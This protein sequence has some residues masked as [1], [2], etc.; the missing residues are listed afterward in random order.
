M[1]YSPTGF[2]SEIVRGQ[3]DELLNKDPFDLQSSP[4]HLR[5]TISK[6]V[7]LPFNKITR[8]ADEEATKKDSAKHDEGGDPVEGG[9]D[10]DQEYPDETG[11]Q[12]DQ[13]GD[14]VG[15]GAEEKA[16]EEDRDA[17]D[18]PD[19]TGQV[20]PGRVAFGSDFYDEQKGDCGVGTHPDGA[21]S[22]FGP[23]IA[24]V[25]D[26]GEGSERETGDELPRPTPSTRIPRLAIDG[27]R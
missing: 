17:T 15:S 16:D 25:G 11:C 21:E 8:I 12:D 24:S 9:V 4:H 10:I 22:R 27:S 20:G 2:I 23:G 6:L 3:T 19:D 7:L 5:Q 1:V 26:G 18:R 14:P 13:P